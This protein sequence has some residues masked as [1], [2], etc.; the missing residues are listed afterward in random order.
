MIALSRTSPFRAEEGRSG[1]GAIEP[2]RGASVSAYY[3][4]EPAIRG[5]KGEP[6][7][8]ALPMVESLRRTSLSAG[9]GVPVS[10]RLRV[11]RTLAR[12]SKAFSRIP[13]RPL[14]GSVC[15]SPISEPTIEV[16]LEQVTF[17]PKHAIAAKLIMH[18][19]EPAIRHALVDAQDK[20]IL[21]VVADAGPYLGERA[22][23]RIDK[24]EPELPGVTI[25][26]DESEP[27]AGQI[28]DLSAEREASLPLAAG[29]QIRTF[30]AN[31]VV[32]G[33]SAAA[34]H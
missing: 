29:W 16:L 15:S 30:T 10:R 19:F 17:K 32:W 6:P 23:A 34:T 18:A 8:A 28:T 2:S 3:C 27:S 22:P 26:G 25:P 20:E 1:I 31:K 33:K 5:G 24:D 11:S 14:A 13:P 9:L 4:P 21:I 12:A 7:G